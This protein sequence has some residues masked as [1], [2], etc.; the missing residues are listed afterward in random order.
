MGARDAVRD[1]TRH[2]PC[3]PYGSVGEADI[4]GACDQRDHAQ[5]RDM[6]RARRADRPFRGLIRT[7][8]QAGGFDTDGPVRHPVTGRPQGGSVSPVRAHLSLHHAL[9][10]WV[11]EV[12]HPHGAGQAA[13]CRDADD[14][15][16]A[17][18]YKREAERFSRGWGKR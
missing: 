1:L 17:F 9:D 4:T 6:L 10:R 5:L 18:Q 15:V 11:A 12:A 8:L 7:W 3:G 13:R 2:L 16:G 14:F